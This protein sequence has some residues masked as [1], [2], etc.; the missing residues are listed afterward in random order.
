MDEEERREQIQLELARVEESAMYSAANQFALS[1]QWGA[2]NLLLGVPASVL[3]AVA[4]VTAL[5]STTGSFWAG[6]VALGASA[7]GAVLTIL[8]A[9]KKATQATSAAN[10]YLEIQTAARQERNIDSRARTVEEARGMLA[11]LTARRDEQNKTASPPNRFARRRGSVVL[12]KGGQ[13]YAVD[14]MPEGKH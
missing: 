2:L 9:S 1:Q 5:S 7:F 3:A 13:D 11:E 8:N 14:A 10:A 12:R 4:G 6:V